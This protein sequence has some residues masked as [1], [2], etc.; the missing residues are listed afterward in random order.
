MSYVF[1]SFI[2]AITAAIH[3][4]TPNDQEPPP[5]PFTDLYTFADIG[6]G[7]SDTEPVDD[8]PPPPTRSL[9]A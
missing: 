9:Q 6:E 4:I 1:I 5:T 7:D 8:V 2:L 3:S